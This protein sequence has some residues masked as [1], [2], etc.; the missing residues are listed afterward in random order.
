MQPTT[1]LLA[2]I[3]AMTIGAASAGSAA[4]WPSQPLRIVVPFA[5]GGA[6][7]TMTRILADK[8]KGELGQPVIVE[9]KPGAGTMLASEYV[10]KAAPDGTT[11][12]MAASSLTIN[13]AVFSRVRYDAVKD[14]A[15]VTLVASPLHVLVVGKTVPASSVKELI[16]LAKQKP[17]GLA[18]GSVGAGT[19]THLEAEMFKMM[20]SVDLLHVPYKGSAPALTDLLGGQIQVM[21]DA[22]ASSRQHIQS[23]AIKV[24][25]VTS[26][27]RASLLQDVPTVA[28][29]GLP[30]YEAVPWL[31]VLAPADTAP[32]IVDRLNAALQ[33]ALKD[34]EVMAKFA[35]LGLEIYAYGPKQ[36][37]DF[38]RTDLAK[39]A[40]TA[41]DANVKVD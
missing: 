12:L 41:K 6:A 19:S 10:Q 20:A 40:K 9:N 23:G 1:K 39:W 27:K 11:F 24:L 30:G 31:G 3:C 5:A 7:D 4:E 2:A 13:P 29:S 17:G 32:A 37:S 35:P 16:A 38:I 34:P 14:F 8:L 36:F 28:E 22:L 15:P 21:F 33:T 18:Y 25:A 26:S